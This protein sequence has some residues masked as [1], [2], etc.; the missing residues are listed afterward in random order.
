MTAAPEPSLISFDPGLVEETVLLAERSLNGEQQREFRAQRDRLYGLSD[1][2]E[3]EARFAGFHAEWF[4]RLALGDEIRALLDEN[5]AFGAHPAP[6]S[7]C[8]VI[9]A[10]GAKEEGA[11][12]HEERG[13]RHEA[14]KPALV[15]KVR[16]ATLLASWRLRLLLRRDLL[17]VADM[18]DPAFEYSL[19]TPEVEGGATR[20][21]LIRDRYRVVWDVSV[22]GRLASRGMS[23][24]EVEGDRRN[25]FLASYG[26]LGSEAAGRFERLFRGPRPTHPQMWAMACSPG[27]A[28]LCPLCRF[29]TPVLQAAPALLPAAL[30]AAIREEFPQWC[31]EAGLCAHCADLYA[32][33]PA[34]FH[35]MGA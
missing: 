6:V 19:A 25:E 34:S 27:G 16:P 1:P 32:S 5:P 9:R 22:D 8:A 35:A 30:I 4:V 24:E 11:D 29:P 13:R 31:P 18:L 17:Q 23:N 20:E 33:R 10:I 14:G 12:L 3:S 7:R 15:I 21:K 28:G 26:A 2:D